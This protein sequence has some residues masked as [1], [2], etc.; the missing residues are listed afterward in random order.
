MGI[1]ITEGG[2]LSLDIGEIIG[3]GLDFS[4]S[5]TTTTTVGE[6]GNIPCP[7]GGWQCA[8]SVTPTVLNVVGTQ[9]ISFEN[10]PN[11]GSNPYDVLIPQ[12]DSANS[13]SL[14]SQ[15]PRDHTHSDR[16]RNHRR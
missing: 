12:V 6:G 3:L 8:L 5:E 11:T 10:C 14:H 4:V 7:M 9:T 15:I 1:T 13:M 2:S 16:R